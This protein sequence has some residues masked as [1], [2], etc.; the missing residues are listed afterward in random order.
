[1]SNG[2]KYD[3]GKPM[4]GLMLKDFS[5][6]LTAIAE[7]STYGCA[8][9]GSPSGW[10]DVENAPH[11]Y[12]DA[13]GRHLLAQSVSGIDEESGLLHAAHLAWNALAVLEL[14]LKA[15]S[16]ALKTFEETLETTG[17]THQ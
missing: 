11:R 8:K 7:V 12:G 16:D 3:E 15:R 5:L 6:A 14:S 2:N 10:K 1:M 17:D 9:Y 13:L 4:V